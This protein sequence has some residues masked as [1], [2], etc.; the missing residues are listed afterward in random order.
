MDTKRPA[1]SEISINS[2]LLLFAPPSTNSGIQ[3]VKWVNCAPLNQLTSSGDVEI[4][5]SGSGSAYLDLSRTLLY[6]KAKILK[7]DGT[8]IASDEKVGAVNFFLHSLWAQMDIDFQQK[9]VCST[10]SNYAYKA[11]LDAYIEYG[12]DAKLSK[13]QAALYFKDSSV[14]M[15]TADP[16][17]KDASIPENKGLKARWQLTKG[18]AEVDMIGVPMAH[19]FELDRYII[20]G[21]GVRVRMVQTKNAF[22]LMAANSEQYKV[23][24]KE[25]TI[26]ACKIYVDPA[27]IQAHN[28]SIKNTPAIYPFMESDIKSFAIAKGSYLI[29]L[30]DVYQGKVPSRLVCA[31]VRAD[32]YSGSYQLNPFSFEHCNIDSFICYAD[33]HALPSNGIITKFSSNSYQEAYHA[34]FSNTDLSS[35]DRGT[36]IT[37]EDFQNGNAIFVFDLDP[38]SRTPSVLPARR[39][40]NLSLEIRMAVPLPWTATLLCY[41]KFP[42]QIQIDHARAIIL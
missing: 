17:P 36:D 26:K 24:L 29:T 33:N 1:N 6:V 10:G 42:S 5:I 3:Q 7:A 18:G 14:A 13:L 32:A 28:E 40:G 20:N 11:I 27:I 22:R 37:R 8:D 34:L 31:I 41:A 23:L 12:R 39:A 15:N 35:P 9:Q 25:V 16:D 21:V 4:Q 38:H 30:D 2:E 19:I